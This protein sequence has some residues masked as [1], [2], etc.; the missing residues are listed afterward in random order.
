MPLKNPALQKMQGEVFI[1]GE[2]ILR[3]LAK[4]KTKHFVLF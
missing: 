1:T 3:Q 4:D 2:L